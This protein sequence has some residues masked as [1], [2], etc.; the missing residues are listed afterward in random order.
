MLVYEK[1]MIYLSGSMIFN[2]RAII[3]RE[4]MRRKDAQC[5]TK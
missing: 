5:N 3:A 2:V 1:T 4:I